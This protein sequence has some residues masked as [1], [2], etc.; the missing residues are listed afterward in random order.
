MT[1]TLHF[2]L[3][4]YVVLGFIVFTII[5]AVTHEAG[6]YIVA[7]KLGYEAK[8]R[9]ASMHYE[10]TDYETFR[11]FHFKNEE[12]LKSRTDKAVMKKYSILM[13]KA[14]K[15]ANLVT[16]G[17]P[18]QTIITGTL[19]FLLLW[20]NRKKIGNKLT[21]LQWSFVF[22]AFFW[23]RQVANFFI[24]LYFLV[25][26][27]EW[28]SQGDE[29]NISEY[30]RLPIWSLNAI[31]ATIAIVLLLIVVFKLIPKQQRFTFILGGLT[32]SIIGFPL[33]MKLL[34]PAILP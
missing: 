2:R 29:T 31:T 33:W 18:V 12:V 8:I 7:K 27:G 11:N 28:T 3:F 25:I 10:N 15:S 17:G 13:H 19:G 4:I 5:G 23:T 21:L 26:R 20:F 6:H 22:M 9:Y 30:F 16:L 1:F 24:G 34:G 32:G 14:R